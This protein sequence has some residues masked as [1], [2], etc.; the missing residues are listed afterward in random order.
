MKG[1]NVL[2]WK[3]GDGVS[4]NGPHDRRLPKPAI[5]GY[6]AVARQGRLDE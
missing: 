4:F 1:F 3:L 2:S 5:V 6:V